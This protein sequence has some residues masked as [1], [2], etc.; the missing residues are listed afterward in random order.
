[1][2]LCSTSQMLRSGFLT[3]AVFECVLVGGS[4]RFF[5]QIGQES[6]KCFNFRIGLLREIYIDSGRHHLSLRGGCAYEATGNR[7]EWQN[8]EQDMEQIRKFAKDNNF[9]IPS[10]DPKA[11]D[12]NTL[13]RL[14]P[15]GGECG[16][17][18]PRLKYLAQV[19]PAVEEQAGGDKDIFWPGECV[20]VSPRNPSGPP[21]NATITDLPLILSMLEPCSEEAFRFNY[22]R[23][24]NRF[25]TA[26][27][28]PQVLSEQ[29]YL[30]RFYPDIER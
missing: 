6:E 27:I 5:V 26:D 23:F 14:F 30:E 3:I 4:E 16:L 7:E 8:V 13:R 11:V 2:L 12:P 9:P 20:V 22:M 10:D 1:M 24:Q 15:G 21:Y 18:D 29:E 25:Q 28:P 19:I 17:D